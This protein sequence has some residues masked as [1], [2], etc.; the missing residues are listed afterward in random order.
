VAVGVTALGAIAN[1]ATLL[2][3]LAVDRAWWQRQRITLTELMV[4]GPR[5]FRQ[6]SATGQ[7]VPAGSRVWMVG[8]AR[9]YYEIRDVHY[10]VV[11]NRDPWLE[12]AANAT[13]AEAVAWL[14]TENVT[15]VLFSWPE[16]ERLRGS[17][18]FPAF[19]TRAWV[20]QLEGAG[21][22][23]IEPPP[24]MAGGALEIYE[25]TVE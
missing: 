9:A 5:I 21:L 24:G 18:G 25:V 17:Y 22:A 11:F 7:I 1:D 12:Y 2:R 20:A 14:R 13:P 16:I 8:E 3:Y 10:T 4:R 15:H 23:R 19:V 6:V